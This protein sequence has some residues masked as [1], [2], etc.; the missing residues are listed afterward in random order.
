[1]KT[2]NYSNMLHMGRQIEK[3]RRIRGMTQSELG[4]S[5]GITKQAV[6]KME[7]TEYMD[8]ERIK[9]VAS[10]LG[11]SHEGLKKFHIEK[12]LFNTINFY[13]DSEG[14]S[15][16]LISSNNIENLPNL[17]IEKTIQIFETLLEKERE[18]Y[19]KVKRA[20]K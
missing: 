17:P 18:K 10:A 5:L 19:E 15:S 2:Q 11:V 16:P 4:E 14:V 8:E 13:E 7:Q 12:V 9:E 20:G 6:S 3:I 1:M